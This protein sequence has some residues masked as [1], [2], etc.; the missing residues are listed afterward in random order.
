MDEKELAIKAVNDAATKA[1]T[2]AVEKLLKEKG[3]D[4]LKSDAGEKAVAEVANNAFKSAK[5]KV[6]EKEFT[7]EEYAKANQEQFDQAIMKFNSEGGQAKGEDLGK[8]LKEVNMDGVKEG[9]KRGEIQLKAPVTMTVS[10][11]VGNTPYLPVPDVRLGVIEQARLRPII[12]D[13]ITKGGTNSSTI[14]W[15]NKKP[16]EGGAAFIAEGTLKP[17]ASFSLEP[18]TSNAKKVAVTFKVS[19]ESL[20]DLPFLLTLINNE[21]LYQLRLKIGTEVLVSPG[22]TTRLKGIDAYAGGY[23]LTSVK[24]EDPDNY[25]AILAARTQLRTLFFNG[26]LAFVNPVDAANMELKKGDNGQYVMPPFS[27][28]DGTRIAG[29]TVV[30]TN[31]IPVGSLL[32]IDSAV[33]NLVPYLGPRIE[34]GWEND[35]FTKNLRTIIV[36][37]RLHLYVSANQVG[38]LLYDTFANIKTAMTI[39]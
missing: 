18:E 3:A 20:E 22:S 39:A 35:D 1:A 15:V 25:G 10:A 37:Q 21:G 6:G 24:G 33:V 31:E 30:E 16:T 19:T 4:W 23:V 34:I 2:E 17:N 12:Q 32:V 9:T 13:Y 14:V 27:T 28:A 7:I 38:G 29:L 26:D 11:T 5:I 8:M 36:E